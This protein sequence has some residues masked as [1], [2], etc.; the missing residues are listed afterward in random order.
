MCTIFLLIVHENTICIENKVLDNV[1][2]EQ[3]KVILL[4]FVTQ[5]VQMYYSTT[6]NMIKLRSK[7]YSGLF[8]KR[9]HIQKSIPVCFKFIFSRLSIWGNGM[10]MYSI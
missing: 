6:L 1:L 5:Y 9:T 10:E 8:V 3:H 4:G 2:G 7:L